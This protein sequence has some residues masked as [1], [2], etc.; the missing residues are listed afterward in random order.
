MF[1]AFL[2]LLSVSVSLGNIHRA[3]YADLNDGLVDSL[4]LLYIQKMKEEET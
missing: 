1:W 2:V 4:M 3:G